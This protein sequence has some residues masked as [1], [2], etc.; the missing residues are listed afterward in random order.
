VGEPGLSKEANGSG[1]GGEG[2]MRQKVEKEE[3]LG[4]GDP[5]PLF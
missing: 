5:Y 1:G 3:D 2:V 4:M